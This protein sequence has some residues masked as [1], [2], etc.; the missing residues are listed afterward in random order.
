VRPSQDYRV[1]VALLETSAPRLWQS[2]AWLELVKCLDPF[3]Q[4]GSGGPRIRVDQ[5][6]ATMRPA[7]YRNLTWD[8]A[9]FSTWTHA[10]A[11]RDEREFSSVA[12]WFPNVA[13]ATSWPDAYFDLSAVYEPRRVGQIL[14]VASGE[15]LGMNAALAAL[16]EHVS[17]TSDPLL[18]AECR[19]P[20]WYASGGAFVRSLD[21]LVLEEIASI[22]EVEGRPTLADL[23]ALSSMMSRRTRVEV[24]AWEPYRR[25]FDG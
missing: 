21:H 4:L 15:T 11:A 17:A 20:F 24:P 6:D 1:V 5:T 3:A 13:T 16:I 25:D 2:D 12:L 18:V 7:R 22:D 10:D 9:S 14:L 19:R 8:E 23:N